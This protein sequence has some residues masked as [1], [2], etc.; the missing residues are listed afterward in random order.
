[1][2]AAEVVDRLTGTAVDRGAKGRDDVYGHGQLDA[3]A[4]LTAPRTQPSETAGPAATVP[5][6]V[7]EPLPL[8]RRAIPPYVFVGVG[9][10]LLVVLLAVVMIA[11]AR[12]N[13]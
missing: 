11:R 6:V 12:R 8:P 7:A 4:A 1:M 5:P 13:R 3:V 2:S 10:L 9:V